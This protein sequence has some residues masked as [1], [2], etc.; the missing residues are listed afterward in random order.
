MTN[1]KIVFIFLLLVTVTFL[2]VHC[3]PETSSRTVANTYQNLDPHVR[4]VG[5]QTCRGCHTEIHNTFMHTGMGLSIDTASQEKSAATFG[6]HALVYDEQSDFYYYPYFKSDTLFIQEYRLA[7]G[8]TVHQRTE[9]VSYII[10][11][12]QHTNSHLSSVNGYLYQMPITYY[13]QDEKWDIAPGF[14][15]DNERFSRFLTTECIT[16]HNNLP[17]FVEGS[18]NKYAEMPKG[19]EC[20]RC[21]GPGEVHVKEKLAGNIVDTSHFI[22]YT[23]VNP[24]DLPRDLQVDVCQRCHLQGLSVLQPNK[25]FFDHRPGMKLSETFNVFLPRYSDSDARFIMASQADRTELSACFKQSEMTCLT[26][27]NPHVS[28]TQT[29]QERYNLACKNCHGGSITKELD[30][31]IQCA[32]SQEV[33]TSNG[34][35]C[36][37]CHMPKSGSTDIPH[38]RITD[39][40]IRK[41]NTIL[42]QPEISPPPPAA[43]RQ[44]LG[45]KILTKDDA[46]PLE[47]ARG[48]IAMFDK[49]VPSPVMLDSAQYYLELSNQPFVEQFST[50]IHYCFAREDY[51][52]LLKIVGEWSNE[53]LPSDGWTA[54][55]VGEAFYK[56]GDFP[57]AKKYYEL[58]KKDLPLHLD[59]REKLGA[60]A[61][62]LKD[63]NLAKAEFNFV[64]KEHPKRPIALTNL[65]YVFALEGQYDKAENNYDQAIQLDPDYEQAIVNKAAIRLLKRD[66]KQGKKLLERALKLNP[67]NLQTQA[68]LQ[69]LNAM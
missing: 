47:M 46:T 6:K 48:Y 50:Q 27:H 29:P 19:I 23:I 1:I 55:R 65:G 40:Y 38:V 43:D 26:C 51:E 18:V 59:F 56:T 52:G 24:R 8:D 14:E 25:T 66:I 64:L 68:M 35:D 57:Q 45:L 41:G 16:C 20:E 17:D 37:G 32:A 4:Y 15:R 33:R 2:L 3:Q 31:K 10:G 44:F 36:A 12:G 21:H 42:N 62:L 7:E 58:A 60:V 9:K 28:V 63:Y 54:Y 49:Y 67:E 53:N 39:H 22:D 5:M 69:Q 61:V 13:T 34:D 11:S 30:G